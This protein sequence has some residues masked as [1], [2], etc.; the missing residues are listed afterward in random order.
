M[1]TLHALGINPSDLMNA[2]QD[3]ILMLKGNS[4]AWK[5]P[6]GW[7]TKRP[8]KDFQPRT[9]E[10]LIRQQLASVHFG[11]GSPRLVL[12]SAGEEMA[13]AIEAARRSRKGR[14]A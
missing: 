13:T 2:Q 1:T 12:T 3:L 10:S 8:G 5:V 14:A 7:R 6:R 4:C 9:G 11:K